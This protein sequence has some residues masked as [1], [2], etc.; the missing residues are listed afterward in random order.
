MSITRA[1]VNSFFHK[2]VEFGEGGTADYVAAHA[3]R[4]AQRG[5]NPAIPYKG[6]VNPRRALE[7]ALKDLEERERIDEASGTVTCGI[8]RVADVHIS[9]ADESA[10]LTAAYEAV[11]EF[12]VVGADVH[13]DAGETAAAHEATQPDGRIDLVLPNY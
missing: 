12:G 10:R 5:K 1:E 3:A 2:E 11:Q 7:A 8:G 9:S 4:Q 6:I 13:S